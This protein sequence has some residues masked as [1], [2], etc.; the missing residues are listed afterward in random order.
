MKLIENGKIVSAL[1]YGDKVDSVDINATKEYSLFLRLCTDKDQYAFP[2]IPSSFENYVFVGGDNSAAKKLGVVVP[3]EKFSEDTVYILVKDNYVVLDGGIRGKLYAVYEFLERFL[4]VRFYAP[5]EYR[6]PR[7]VNVEIP[8]QEIIY[9]PK[10]TFRQCFSYDVRWNTQFAARVRCNQYNLPLGFSDLGGGYNC[11]MPGGHSSFNFLFPPEHPE[12]GFDK[13]PEYYSYRKDI[14]GRVGRH[15]TMKSGAKWGEG[16]MCWSNPEVVDI[17]EKRIKQ[18]ILDNPDKNI[19]SVSQNDWT[20]YCQCPNCEAQ[21]LKYGKDGEPRW[22]APIIICL[23]ELSRRIKKWTQE[24]ERVKGREIFLKTMAYNY[25][26]EPPVGLEVDDHVIIN[27][28]IHGCYYHQIDDENCAV[29]N[30]V[31][32]KLDGWNK[33]TNGL[34]LWDYANNFAFTLLYN[35]VLRVV[36]KRMQYYAEHGVKGIFLEYTDSKARGNTWFHVRQYLYSMLQWNPYLDFETEYKMA[37]EHFYGEGAGCMMELER[38][39]QECIDADAKRNEENPE[40]GGYHPPH[41]Y[42]ITKDHYSEEF[43]SIGEDLFEIAFNKVKCEKTLL[44]IKK[45]YAIFKFAKCYMKRGTNYKEMQDALD[46]LERFGIKGGRLNL[47]I[48]HYFGG[49]R[50]DLFLDEIALRNKKNFLSKLIEVAR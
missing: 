8:D 46:G 23:N 24:D 9:T 11:A 27:L 31:R 18:W 4:G 41:A 3:R 30:T 28:I 43:F 21:A 5:E 47:F 35:T 19:F 10:I 34:F 38:R 45:E 48:N 36:Q 32:R 12:T 39:F 15:Y 7:A 13:H 42:V 37:M 14:N 17:L 6:T 22:V 26:E 50:D 49:R 25:G 44:N 40:L 1:V 20:E 33:L 29:S 2:D 16:E